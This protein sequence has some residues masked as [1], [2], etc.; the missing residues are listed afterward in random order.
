[1]EPR[2]IQIIELLKEIKSLIFGVMLL[3]GI[4]GIILILGFISVAGGAEIQV[5]STYSHFTYEGIESGPGLKVS[6]TWDWFRVWG[7]YSHSCRT[8]HR[9]EIGPLDLFGVGVGIREYITPRLSFTLDAGYFYPYINTGHSAPE[10]M[11]LYIVN[12]LPAIPPTGFSRYTYEVSG[13]PGATLGLNYQR[14]RWSLSASYTAL[15]C[16]ERISAYH[17]TG[18]VSFPGYV[19]Y[20][21][22]SLGLGVTFQ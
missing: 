9:Q 2:L 13:A 5:S 1:M 12:E 11:Y 14:G 7:S 3:L 19:D 17:T 4:V 8:E 6:S 18:F 22:F 20:S 10:A 15:W 21:H 16:H